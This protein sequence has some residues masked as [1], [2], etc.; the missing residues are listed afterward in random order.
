MG[1]VAFY[2]D[3]RAVI[4]DDIGR[5][6]LL[7]GIFYVSP[8]LPLRSIPVDLVYERTVDERIVLL[9]VHCDYEDDQGARGNGDAHRLRYETDLVHLGQNE[10]QSPCGTRAGE[11]DIVH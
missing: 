7:V 11:D 3:S 10:S 4:C 5:D 2:D 1:L 8:R 9:V 6:I